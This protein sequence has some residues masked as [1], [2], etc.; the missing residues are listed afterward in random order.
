MSEY[1]NDEP[2]TP[3]VEPIVEGPD[4]GDM[5]NTALMDLERF[6]PEI[7]PIVPV[8]TRPL[9]PKAMLPLSLTA[10]KL[11]ETIKAAL[12]LP[13]R[14]MGLVLTQKEEIDA[15]EDLI[16]IE[17][18][19]VGTAV[20]VLKSEDGPDG[21]LMLLVASLKRFTI[22]EI[23]Q[24]EGILF[25]RVRYVE[26]PKPDIEESDELYDS[27]IVDAFLGVLA[28]ATPFGGLWKQATSLLSRGA[29]ALQTGTNSQGPSG[30]PKA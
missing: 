25:G 22:E 19:H 14:H 5:A 12:R 3:E 20:G 9:F 6:L 8:T 10:G 11:T 2:E 1:K 21:G 29:N 26:A 27:E 28:L 30:E 18:H 4:G 7:I 17:L 24:R 16:N 23:H 15:K 13:S